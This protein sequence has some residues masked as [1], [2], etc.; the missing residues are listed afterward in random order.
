MQLEFVYRE[1]DELINSFYTYTCPSVFR[2]SE[3]DK[4]WRTEIERQLPGDF[5]RAV[6]EDETFT[7]S[8]GLVHF[9]VQAGPSPEAEAFIDW[10][11]ERSAGEV[12]EILSPHMKQFPEELGTFRDKLVYYLSAWYEIYFRYL[13][14]RISVELRKEAEARNRQLREVTDKDAFVEEVTNGLV[15]EP[16]PHL[17]KL[18]LTPQY[19]ARPLNW[20]FLFDSLTWCHYAF[21]AA[22]QNDEDEPSPLLREAAKGLSDVNRLKILRFL[23][24]GPRSYTEVAKHIGLAKST[25]YEHMLILRSAG[26]IRTNVAGD[27]ASTYGLRREGIARLNKELEQWLLP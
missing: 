12:Y 23:R 1:A 11:G 7:K 22:G 26:L 15:F 19:H 27:S 25:V 21:D 13:D 9:L 5:K 4:K 20:I 2:R 16:Q 18:V 17:K 24:N 14:P 8:L 10:L 6:D 3:R